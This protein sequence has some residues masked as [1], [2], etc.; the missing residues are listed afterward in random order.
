MYWEETEEDEDIKIES[1]TIDIAF[2]VDCKK[3]SADHAYDLFISIKEIIPS[4][5]SIDNLAIHTI[6]GSSSGAGWE[7]PK[8][9]IYLSKRA[10]LTIRSLN[11]HIELIKELDNKTL[12]VGK[13]SVKLSKPNVKKLTVSDT[14]FCRYLIMDIS[15]TEDQFLESVKSDIEKL[16]IHVKK[17][18]CGKSYNV[19]TSKSTYKTCTFLITEMSP[20]DS[21]KL[22]E[23]GLGIGKLF[24]CGIFLPYKS[25][26]AVAVAKERDE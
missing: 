2:H 20:Q 14:L 12:P 11:K 9:E 6:H 10:R 1:N 21:I 17:M 18:M 23:I 4:I 8:D 7:R 24:G 16:G 5:E 13:Y 22:Q 15:K 26:A 3:I 25:I 19:K